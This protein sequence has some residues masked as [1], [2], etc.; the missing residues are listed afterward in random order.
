MKPEPWIVLP[1]VHCPHENKP[2]MRRVCQLMLDVRPAGL[3]ISGD[4][5]NYGSVSRHNKGSLAR[6]AGLTLR[7]EY[8]AQNTLL[9]SIGAAVPR[10]CRK[11]FIEGNHE[12]SYH[13]WVSDGDNAKVDGAIT[14]PREGLFLDKRGYSYHGNWKEASVPIGPHLEIVHGEYCVAHCAK[15]HLDEHEGSVM[16]GH[17]HRFQVHL[18]G[19]R[20]AYNIGWLGDKNSPAFDYATASQKR[21]W[22]NGLGLVWLM[23]D[24][25]FIPQPI[26]C[27]Q[28]RFVHGGKLY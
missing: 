18:T 14:S 22:C 27:W 16:F 15:R 25:S 26:Q 20:G 21:R 19:K 7:D 6:L 17:T 9:N 23:S 1:D 24:G 12:D 5:G 2:L 11:F 4:F 10:G 28:S 13:R 3:V 8:D